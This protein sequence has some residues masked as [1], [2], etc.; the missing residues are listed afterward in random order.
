MSTDAGSPQLKPCPRNPNC[1]SSQGKGRQYIEP[2]PGDEA[3]WERLPGVL[4]AMAGV[5]IVDQT[6]DSIRAEAPWFEEELSK[7]NQAAQ[8]ASEED[9]NDD[10]PF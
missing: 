1:V 5:R 8:A 4:E 10:I 9:F 6:A 2:L 3:T 7:Q